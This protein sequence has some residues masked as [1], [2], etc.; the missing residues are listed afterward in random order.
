MSWNGQL[1][2]HKSCLEITGWINQANKQDNIR[3]ESKNKTKGQSH[4]LLGLYL[5]F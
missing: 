3:K 2:S 4:G 1:N 5:F